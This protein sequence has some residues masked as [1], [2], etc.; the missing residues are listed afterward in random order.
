MPSLWPKTTS[1]QIL[2]H[3]LRALNAHIFINR[4]P[5]GGAG[6]VA[7]LGAEV[8]L[9]GFDARVA[10]AQFE[11]EVFLFE[12]ALLLN[13]E[14]VEEERGGEALAPDFVFQQAGG[15]Q[16]DVAAFERAVGFQGAR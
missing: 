2:N 15:F 12:H 8:E 7:G 6:F 9:D 5:E 1:L 13:L 10:F 3:Q 16:R 11:F 4:Q 14:F